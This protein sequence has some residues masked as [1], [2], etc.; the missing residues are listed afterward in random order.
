MEWE[1]PRFVDGVACVAI[2]K[3]MDA[4][5]ALKKANRIME[6]EGARDGIDFDKEKEEDMNFDKKLTRE[7]GQEKVRWLGC[8]LDQNIS[9]IKHMQVRTQKA[10]QAWGK[11]KPLGISMGGMSPVGWRGEPTQA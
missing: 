7:G 1:L 9:F 4:T 8:W 2:S 5:R 3:E 6:V 11:L 10:R